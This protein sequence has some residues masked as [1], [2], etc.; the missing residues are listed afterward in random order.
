MKN[1][2]L[3]LFCMATSIMSHAQVNNGRIVVSVTSNQT[4]SDGATV[5]LFR[6]KDSSLVKIA[7]TDKAGQAEFEN[8]P[9][10]QYFL[11][12]T[13]VG[14]ATYSSAPFSLSEETP[15]FRAPAINLTSR[16]NSEMQGVTVTAKKPF[17][18]KLN[19]RIVVNVEN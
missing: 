19:D 13:A 18:Q 1:F 14:M 4:P 3:I 12:A 9:Y 7:V 17:I 6:N 8:I 16:S 5:E 11:R 15:S 10:N 2:T